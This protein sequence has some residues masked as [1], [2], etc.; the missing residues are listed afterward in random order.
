[1]KSDPYFACIIYSVNSKYIK[2]IN[3]RP[4]IMK[5]LE[6]NRGR[7]LQRI[8]FVNVFLDIIPNGQSTKVKIDKKNFIKYIIICI[9]K[10]TINRVK[11]QPKSEDKIFSKIYTKGLIFRIYKQILQFSN[12]KITIQLK[13][14]QRISTG[15][16]LN[17]IFKWPTSI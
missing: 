4:K 13:N 6:I 7:K 14:G 9:S 15:I 3:V 1:M 12:N 5:L 2:C 16:S 10:E 17:K 8:G 11:K